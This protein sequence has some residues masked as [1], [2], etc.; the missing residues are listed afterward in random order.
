MK[1]HSIHLQKKQNKNLLYRRK[2]VYLGSFV[3]N[4][5]SCLWEAHPRL[6]YR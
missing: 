5:L 3:V 2:K 4:L 1:V 6:C